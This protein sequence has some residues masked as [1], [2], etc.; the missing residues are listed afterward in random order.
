MKLKCAYCD[1]E[2]TVKRCR[3]RKYNYCGVSHQLKFEYENGLRNRKPSIALYKAHK[4]KCSGKNHYHWQGGKRKSGRGYIIINKHK[5][6]EHRFI[7]EKYL[8]RELNRREVVHHLDR[9]RA[10]N[11]IGNLIVMDIAEHTALHN[12]EDYI[13]GVR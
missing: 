8:R 5:K 4:L 10:N 13:C 2:I 9:D 11:R 1:K 7:M 6:R 12:I 3:V